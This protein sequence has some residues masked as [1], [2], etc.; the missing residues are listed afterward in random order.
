MKR[1]RQRVLQLFG[2]HW[3]SKGISDLTV[4]SGLEGALNQATEG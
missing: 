3:V 4:S 2:F 1:K